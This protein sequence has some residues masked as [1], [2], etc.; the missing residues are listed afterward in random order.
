MDDL[1]DQNSS[2]QL[3]IQSKQR[4]AYVTR[5]K[6]ASQFRMIYE[7]DVSFFIN[8]NHNPHQLD[9]KN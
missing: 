8:L 9:I 7:D 1:N 2:Q 6:N 3:S 5:Y 4:V